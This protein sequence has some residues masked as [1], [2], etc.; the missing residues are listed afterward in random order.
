MLQPRVRRKGG[1][2]SFRYPREFLWILWPLLVITVAVLLGM[3]AAGWAAVIG[4]PV[5]LFALATE[6]A[7]LRGM[8][9]IDGQGVHARLFRTRTIAAAGIANLYIR[10]VSDGD[11][12]AE[13][14]TVLQE[15]GTQ[16]VLDATTRRCNANGSAALEQSLCEAQQILGLQPELIRRPGTARSPWRM[17]FHRENTS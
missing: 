8:A 11:R 9:W 16:V 15:D 17:F 10:H 12:H 14:I 1:V 2:L 13:S 6:I 5:F 3:A 4:V 7:V